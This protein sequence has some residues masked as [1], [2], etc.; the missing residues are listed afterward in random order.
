[1]GVEGMRTR[2]NAA[3]DSVACGIKNATTRYFTVISAL[4]GLP[5]GFDACL[6]DEEGTAVCHR[7]WDLLPSLPEAIV[8][9]GGLTEFFMIRIE[10]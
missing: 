7:L 9:I 1:M 2:R 8:D 4:K 3:E 6:I 10:K 5:R